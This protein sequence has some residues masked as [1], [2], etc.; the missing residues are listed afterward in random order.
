MHA[1]W[2]GHMLLGSHDREGREERQGGDTDM[3]AQACCTSLMLC[4]QA[5]VQDQS[6]CEGVSSHGL[7]L[8]VNALEWGDQPWTGWSFRS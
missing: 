2:A 8:E 1:C 6:W 4:R 7:A 5:S 3:T